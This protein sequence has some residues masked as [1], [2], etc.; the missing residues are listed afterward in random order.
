[1]A[2]AGGVVFVG[3]T[4]D[5]KF[6]AFD[7]RTGRELWAVDVGAAAH[8]VSMSYLGRD[9]R[10]YV[11]LVVS[12][13]GFLGDKTVPPAVTGVRP[14]RSGQ[15]GQIAS[16]RSRCVGRRNSADHFTEYLVNA[17]P[18]WRSEFGPSAA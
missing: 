17:P 15:H 4:L 10:Q 18:A 12:G 3:G 6:R 5:D 1:M 8:A 7:S 16:R 13:G 11:A 9:G 14:A 2:T